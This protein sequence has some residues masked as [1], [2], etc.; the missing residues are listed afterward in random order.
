MLPRGQQTL[1]KVEIIDMITLTSE[2]QAALQQNLLQDIHEMVGGCTASRDTAK[3]MQEEATG[4]GIQEILKNCVVQMD[5]GM[6]LMQAYLSQYDD[7][8]TAATCNALK[9]VAEEW[10]QVDLSAIPKGNLQDRILAS[11]MVRHS[12]Y[13]KAGLTH[14]AAAMATLGQTEWS[15]RFTQAVSG[16]DYAIEAQERIIRGEQV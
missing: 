13:A 3:V 2:E 4:N 14:Y 7:K 15:E 8:G 12:Y 1:L 6:D 11:R 9:P 16:I 10:K 5:M